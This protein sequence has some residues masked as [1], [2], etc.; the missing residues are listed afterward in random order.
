MSM[1]V[2][3]RLI[4]FGDNSACCV[5]DYWCMLTSK[6]ALVLSQCTESALIMS[7]HSTLTVRCNLQWWKHESEKKKKK[8]K[9]SAEHLSHADTTNWFIT[10]ER[11]VT[12]R[13]AQQRKSFACAINRSNDGDAKREED[14]ED[15]ICVGRD[16]YASLCCGWGVIQQ[17][18]TLWSDW[19]QTNKPAENTV[20]LQEGRTHLSFPGRVWGHGRWGK[21]GQKLDKCSV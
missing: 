8:K 10:K 15:H 19:G 5:T 18:C 17:A 7:A 11:W 20:N 13:A 2:N 1:P 21:V 16:V 6:R 4:R 14:E 12:G 9:S 3:M